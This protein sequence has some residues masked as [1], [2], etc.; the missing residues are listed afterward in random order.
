MSY[1]VDGL[2]E[3]VLIDLE[4]GDEQGDEQ[5]QWG[6]MGMDSMLYK[7]VPPNN[8]YWLVGIVMSFVAWSLDL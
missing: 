5:R 4:I 7:G 6:A 2:G 3:G 8:C 1:E